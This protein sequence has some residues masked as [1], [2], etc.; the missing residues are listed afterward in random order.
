L[1]LRIFNIGGAGDIK[2]QGRINAISMQTD[3]IWKREYGNGDVEFIIEDQIFFS[4]D[5][6]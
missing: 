5:Q 2:I 3:G 6:T 1:K 4:L